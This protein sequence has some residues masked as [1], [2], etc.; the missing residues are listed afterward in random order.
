M[1]Y[2]AM[3]EEAVKSLAAIDYALGIGDDGCNDLE[4]TLFRIAEL[5]GEVEAQEE[6]PLRCKVMSGRIDMGIGI[7][8]LRFA[9]EQHDGLWDGESPYS[10]PV[11]KITDVQTFAV[12]VAR[13]INRESENGSTLLTRMLDAAI[14]KAVEGGC[15]GVD[16]DA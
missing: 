3:F 9:A 11:V 15:E 14:A 16:H 1:N 4:G 5:K 12:E 7:R 8:I 10:V 6:M 2:K 13:E